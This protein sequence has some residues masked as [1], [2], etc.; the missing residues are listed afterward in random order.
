MTKLVAY[1]KNVYR[2][3]KYTLGETGMLLTQHVKVKGTGGTVKTLRHSV[4]PERW[5]FS[6]TSKKK[7]G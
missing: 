6:H 2:E 4:T 7:A 3:L 1:T 5:K